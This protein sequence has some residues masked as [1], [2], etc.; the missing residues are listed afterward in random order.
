MAL[1]RDAADEGAG[2]RAE[3]EGGGRE[4]SL[5]RTEVWGDGHGK[6]RVAQADE[7]EELDFEVAEGRGGRT[8]GSEAEEG[9]VVVV[10]VEGEEE[11]EEES[12]GRGE[13]VEVCF[14]HGGEGELWP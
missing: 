2:A 1:G 9:F 13:E 11:G 10:D 6:E 4:V 8:A 7:R 12:E 5:L 3:R 14:V